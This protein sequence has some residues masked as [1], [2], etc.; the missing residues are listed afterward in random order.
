MR[1]YVLTGVYFPK[2]YHRSSADFPGCSLNRTITLSPIRESSPKLLLKTRVGSLDSDCLP[3]LELANGMSPTLEDAESENGEEAVLERKP[4]KAKRFR[5]IEKKTRKLWSLL[6][7]GLICLG[8]AVAMVKY[9]YSLMM[10]VDTHRPED[11]YHYL[12][13]AQY[14]DDRFFHR[15][16]YLFR[17]YLISSK[18]SPHIGEILSDEIKSHISNQKAL[19]GNISSQ[20]AISLISSSSSNATLNHFFISMIG[21]QR[22]LYLQTVITKLLNSEFGGLQN[23][24]STIDSYDSKIQKLKTKAPETLH[25]EID[26]FWA[27]YKNVHTPAIT[28]NCAKYLSIP[29]KLL[30]EYDKM[31]KSKK[32]DCVPVAVGIHWNAFEFSLIIGLAITIITIPIAVICYESFM[33][34]FGTINKFI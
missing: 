9:L 22:S 21:A 30:E 17:E 33:W 31:I 15:F 25:K 32:I 26:A 20:V 14:M 4:S 29:E 27:T 16:N 24:T 18:P 23:V 2:T 34:L 1:G 28:E 10:T 8:L 5:K 19:A 7:T 6:L 3:Q 11:D 12:I 13:K